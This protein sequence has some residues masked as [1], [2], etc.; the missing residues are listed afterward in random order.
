MLSNKATTSSAPHFSP[1]WKSGTRTRPRSTSSTRSSTVSAP[2][3]SLRSG[4]E[5]LALIMSVDYHPSDWR[6]SQTQEARA[7]RHDRSRPDS[8]GAEAAQND[9]ETVDWQADGQLDHL[10]PS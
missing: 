8:E 6:V 2:A 5:E 3:S 1:R 10:L 7:I 4:W 9:E